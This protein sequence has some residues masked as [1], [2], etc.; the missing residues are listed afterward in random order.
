V[1]EAPGTPAIVPPQTLNPP[2]V[3]TPAP[4]QPA[5]S[6]APARHRVHH[7]W[8]RHHGRYHAR[9][10]GPAYYPGV[11]E[12]DPPYPD[13]CHESEVWSGYYAPYWKYSCSW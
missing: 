10:L 3:N 7:R 5:L 8:R 12:F 11:G 1:P 4:A 2:T 9:S 13:V 6:P